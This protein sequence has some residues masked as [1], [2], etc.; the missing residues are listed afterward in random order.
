MGSER[1]TT[2]LATI[3]KT[4]CNALIDT[5]A[6]RSCI[7]EK[8]Y[9]Q[10]NLPP[11]RELLRTHLRPAT[12]GSLS[13]IGTTQCTFKL[14]E[15]EFTNTFIVCRH[16]LR[17]IIIG[18]DFLKQKQ[19]F[20]GYSEVGKYVLEYKHLELVSSITVHESPQLVLTKPVRIPQH[21]LV[22]LNT[23]CTAKDHVG[24][25]YKVRT[26]HIIQNNHPNLTILSTVHRI[27]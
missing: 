16:L 24:K 19:I 15:K 26:N 4:V 27:D 25:L 17:P 8:F 11:V 7:I 5:G 2:F 22:V 3:N 13:P 23:R 12:G 9:K 6:S 1:G 18:A 20:V 10:I 14:G 21:S